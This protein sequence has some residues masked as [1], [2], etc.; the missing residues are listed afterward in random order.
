MTSPHT[1]GNEV[2]VTGTKP[3]R[4]LSFE[5]LPHISLLLLYFRYNIVFHR[6]EDVAVYTFIIRIELGTALEVLYIIQTGNVARP[7][8]LCIHP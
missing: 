8:K 6:N 5:H 4:K 1:C 3:I 2:T 7:P